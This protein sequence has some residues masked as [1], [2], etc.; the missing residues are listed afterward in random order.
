MPWRGKRRVAE[1]GHR[2]S[3]RRRWCRRA[4]SRAA[5]L[6]YK[7]TTVVDSANLGERTPIY[8]ETRRRGRGARAALLSVAL[9]C[10]IRNR[11]LATMAC[12]RRGGKAGKGAHR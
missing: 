6:P 7:T 11:R 2:R 10:R 4:S 1:G 9:S 3:R 8:D 5:G 12:A